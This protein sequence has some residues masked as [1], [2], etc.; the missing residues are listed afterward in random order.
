VEG[1]AVGVE[2]LVEKLGKRLLLLLL[3]EGAWRAMEAEAS[4]QCL[5]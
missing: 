5:E 3:G 4:C 1:G 2:E